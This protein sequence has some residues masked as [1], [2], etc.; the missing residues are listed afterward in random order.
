MKTKRVNP[1][2]RSDL[3]IAYPVSD[4]R[5]RLV[6]SHPMNPATAGVASHYETA[7]GLKI[8]RAA[9]DARDPRRVTLTTERMSG[10]D[11]TIDSVRVDGAVRSSRGIRLAQPTSP[12]FLHG[13]ASIEALRRAHGAELPQ[14]S[15]FIGMVA[16]ASCSKNGGVWSGL[17]SLGF[18]FLHEERGGP[19][20]SIKVVTDLEG[21]LPEAP[22]A[23]AKLEP[24]T[25][26]H[27]LWA[28]GVIA[29]VN[30]ETQL[31]DTGYMEGSL[32]SPLK[33]PPPHPIKLADIAGERVKTAAAKSLEG[34]IVRVEAVV[35][36]NVASPPPP[37]PL[38][39][40]GVQLTKGGATKFVDAVERGAL[41]SAVLVQRGGGSIDALLLSPC[42]LP[43]HQGQ[44]FRSIRAIVSRRRPD[45]FE[46]LIEHD[47]DLEQ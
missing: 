29:E 46:L 45:A 40:F 5:L 47:R 20:S 38:A 11:L 12:A 37:P 34:V 10:A 41:R 17:L 15:R 36:E 6:F 43:L 9:V 35:V 26:L 23:F 4:Q 16:S 33:I 31:V 2:D 3:L 27:P 42:T 39:P 32:L 7:K 30:G 18:T 44:R 8:L 19:Y 1:F 14:T 13:I 22:R 28:G 24:G 25:T 21:R